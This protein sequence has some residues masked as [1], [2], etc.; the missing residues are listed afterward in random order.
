MLLH[1]AFLL[2]L[3]LFSLLGITVKIVPRGVAQE[4]DRTTGIVLKHI[5]LTGEYYE[6]EQENVEA[7]AGESVHFL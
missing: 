6:G 2:H 5:D 4:P 3:A 1:A 7:A